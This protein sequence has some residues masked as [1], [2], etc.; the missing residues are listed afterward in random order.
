MTNNNHNHRHVRKESGL[1]HIMEHFVLPIKV[2]SRE[3][4]EFFGLFSVVFLLSASVF[5]FCYPRADLPHQ[6]LTFLGAAHATWLMLFFENPL[7]YVDSWALTP[8]FFGLPIFGL[9]IVAEG[10]VHLGNLLFQQKRY[11]KEWQQMIASTYE[12]HVVVC[13]LGNV[14]IRVVQHLLRLG[15]KTV[16]IE[17]DPTARFIKEAEALEVP[18]LVGDV[19]DISTLEKASVKHAKAIIAVTDNDLANLEACLTARE[20][21]PDLRVVIRMFDQKLAKKIEKSLGIGAAYSSSARSSR[22]FAQAAV[23]ENILDSFEFG[24]TIINAYQLVVKANTALVGATI[25]DVRRN[26]EVTVLL[27]EKH[28][29]ELDWNPSPNNILRVDDKLLIMTDQDGIKRMEKSTKTLPPF[30]KPHD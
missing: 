16:A 26:H 17:S 5:Y 12:K 14:G 30:P 24:G 22:L 10:V 29:G 21:N 6:Q 13:G 27:H 1:L 23:S 8:L 7:P 11:S 28:E 15:E 4:K 19:R 3:F 25:D 18:V 2:I 20:V 9:V